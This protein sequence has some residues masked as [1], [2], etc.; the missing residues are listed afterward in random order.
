MAPFWTNN[1]VYDTTQPLGNFSG[2][3][4]WFEGEQLAFNRGFDNVVFNQLIFIGE[5]GRAPAARTFAVRSKHG[6][7]RLLPPSLPCLD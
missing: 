6:A 3:R 2:M 1:L 4:G 7:S 5:D